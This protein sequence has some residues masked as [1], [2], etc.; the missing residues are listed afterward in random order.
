MTVALIPLKARKPVNGD[1]V[2]KPIPVS[3]TE[4]VVRR[5]AAAD[6]RRQFEHLSLAEL[7]A[8]VAGA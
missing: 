6:K 7:C 4:Y 5:R 1:V 2:A 3:I 8:R